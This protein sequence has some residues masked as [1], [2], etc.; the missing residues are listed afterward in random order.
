[1][2]NNVVE[3]MPFPRIEVGPATCHGQPVWI[4][5]IIDT[6]GG[7]IVNEGTGLNTL[8]SDVKHDNWGL[9]IRIV[10]RFAA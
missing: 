4:A 10:K 2:K 7:Y 5:R 6:D 9:P 8:V 1:V 3:L